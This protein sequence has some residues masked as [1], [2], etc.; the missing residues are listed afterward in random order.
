MIINRIRSSPFAVHILTLFTGTFVAQLI[1]FL[2]SPLLTR[3]YTAE[4]FG[5]L[6][7]FMSAVA[8]LGVIASFRYEFAIVLPSKEDDAWQLLNLSVLLAGGMGLLSLV[9]M[10][11]FGDALLHFFEAAPLRPFLFFIPLA[12]FLTGA[13]QAFNYWSTRHRTFK[14]NARA[15]VTQS[16]AIALV[17]VA[18]G[19][20]GF[21]ALGLIS[22]YLAGLGLAAMVLGW[23]LLRKP[24]EW[25]RSFSAPGIKANMKRYRSFAWINTPHAL[26]DSLVDN[27][28][29][30]LISFAFNNIVLGWYSWAF[31]LLKAPVGIIGSAVGQVFFERA[32]A[33]NRDKVSVRPL[34]WRI[35]R[36]MIAI[37]LP[38]FVPLMIFAPDIFAFV[39]SEAFREAG[40]IA[41]LLIP[42]IF[43]NFLISPF[44]NLPIICNKQKQALLIT[45]VDLIL[46]LLALTAG[47]K[48]NDYMTGFALMAAAST[49]LSLFVLIWYYR[50]ARNP[51][52]DAYA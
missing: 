49:A 29:V 13:Y 44:S 46:R 8:I 4:D 25:F 48:L 36:N 19:F 41:Q 40:E 16:L 50:L 38:V 9:F 15:R 2:V 51:V 37:A 24:R 22:G 6:S 10:L 11:F 31:R 27:G 18:L 17:S 3:L 42:W 5:I 1:P 26:L 35:Q 14:I 23:L 7:L 32:S 12:V 39:F 33:M 43:V 34:M 21:G 52:T 47:W 30:F 28:I 45:M 20:A